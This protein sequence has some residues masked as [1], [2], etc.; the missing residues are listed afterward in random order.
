MK[1]QY[2]IVNN[3]ITFFV[4]IF[5]II[6]FLKSLNIKMNNIFTLTHNKNDNFY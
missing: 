2:L 3:F 5:S 1:K 4:T 6:L